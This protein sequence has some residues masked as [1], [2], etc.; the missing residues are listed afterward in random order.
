MGRKT[1]EA[2]VDRTFCGRLYCEICETYFLS[3]YRQGKQ[4]GK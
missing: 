3:C 1:L 2:L 4:N